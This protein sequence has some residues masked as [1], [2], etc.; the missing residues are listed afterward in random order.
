MFTRTEGVRGFTLDFWQ[1]VWSRAK[2]DR[3][4]KPQME[5]HCIKAWGEFEKKLKLKHT[6]DSESNG[7]SYRW[8]ASKSDQPTKYTTSLFL[9]TTRWYR[10]KTRL[11][12]KINPKAW[13]NLGEKTY[14]GQLNKDANNKTIQYHCLADKY[15]NE[16]QMPSDS[17]VS[18]KLPLQKEQH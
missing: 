11:S 5:K 3:K 14:S 1:A 16:H 6:E 4:A 7:V 15:P 9:A 18:G 17:D 10:G 8:E 13:T 12:S 2:R